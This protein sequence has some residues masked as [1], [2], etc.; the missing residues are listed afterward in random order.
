MKFFS[1]SGIDVRNVRKEDAGMV[2]SEVLRKIMDDIEV[3]NGL[4]DLGYSSEDVP[5][6]VKGTLPQVNSFNGC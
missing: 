1:L 3:P 5:D 4:K 6:L 2:L